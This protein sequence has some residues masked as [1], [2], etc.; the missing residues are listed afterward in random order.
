[1]EMVFAKYDKYSVREDQEGNIFIEPTEQDIEKAQLSIVSMVDEEYPDDDLLNV[2]NTS[3]RM[4]NEL[5]SLLYDGDRE[6]GEDLEDRI[7]SV[8][9]FVNKYGNIGSSV[10][11]VEETRGIERAPELPLGV[12]FTRNVTN[13]HRR[14]PSIIHNGAFIANTD[15]LSYKD[16]LLD[17]GTVFSDITDLKILVD[18]YKEFGKIKNIKLMNRHLLECNIAEIFDYNED[19]ELVLT[20][21]FDTIIGLAYWQLKHDISTKMN[22]KLCAHC[23]KHFTAKNPKAKYCR[24]KCDSNGNS[25]CASAARYRIGDLRRKVRSG[26]KKGQSLEY[27]IEKYNELDEQEILRIYNTDKKRTH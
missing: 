6:K 3:R 20:A 21:F 1:M 26:I 22:I 25:Q 9:E 2:N 4:Y 5:I 12:R 14:K 16:G 18:E 24:N 17:S 19:N 27:L 11:E 15:C 10:I 23:G 7:E 8:L 13:I